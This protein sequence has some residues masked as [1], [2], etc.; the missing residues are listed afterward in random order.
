MQHSIDPH[1]RNG[2]TLNGREQNSSQCIPK[3]CSETSLKRLGMEVPKR[4]RECFHIAR[5]SL[6]FLET[7]HC[8]DLRFSLTPFYLVLENGPV[9]L[10]PSKL[11]GLF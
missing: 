7:F 5:K 8:S 1:S 10:E 9:Q 6:R 2:G 4:I 3:R 11:S